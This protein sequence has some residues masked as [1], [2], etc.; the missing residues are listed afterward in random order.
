MKWNR[1]EYIDLMT[2]TSCERQMFVELFG[3]LVG[4][5]EEWKA[6]GAAEEELNLTAFDWDYVL[7]VSCEGENTRIMGGF[8]PHV[9]ENTWDMLHSKGTKIFCQDSNGKWKPLYL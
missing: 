4:L 1:Q 9:I 6:Q 7:I 5:E 2:F 3:P 8:K